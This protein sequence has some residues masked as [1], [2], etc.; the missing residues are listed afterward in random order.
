MQSAP[1]RL[2]FCG[3]HCI[4]VEGASPYLPRRTAEMSSASNTIL[5]CINL[6]RTPADQFGSK[7]S[8]MGVVVFGDD[9][10]ALSL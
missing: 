9:D 6:A 5:I 7:R 10:R 2:R 4:P 8:I 1:R 3:G